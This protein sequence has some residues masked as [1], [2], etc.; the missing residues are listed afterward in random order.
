MTIML[1]CFILLGGE[2]N[3]KEKYN[4]VILNHLLIYINIIRHVQTTTI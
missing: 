4:T 1:L 2:T 3:G